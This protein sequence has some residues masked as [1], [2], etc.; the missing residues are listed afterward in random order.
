MYLVIYTATVNRHILVTFDAQI[1]KKLDT[2]KFCNAIRY[3][4]LKF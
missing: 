1:K 2:K 3:Y 4:V